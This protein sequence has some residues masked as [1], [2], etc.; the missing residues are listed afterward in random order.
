MMKHISLHYSRFF[1]FCGQWRSSWLQAVRS[2][3]LSVSVVGGRLHQND[4]TTSNCCVT[5]ALYQSFALNTASIYRR[6]K[7]FDNNDTSKHRNA[8]F[9]F[10]KLFSQSY[11]CADD[12][13]WFVRLKLGGAINFFATI[14]IMPTLRPID[15]DCRD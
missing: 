8:Y 11:K 5:P 7:F 9:C 1:S 13:L 10:H 15:V 3:R 12:P 4:R 14:V 2:R 6:N